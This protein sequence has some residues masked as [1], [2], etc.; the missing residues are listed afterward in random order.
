MR[1]AICAGAL[2]SGAFAAHVTADAA[3]PSAP[4]V[5][6][7]APPALDLELEPGPAAAVDTEPLPI[8][9][10]TP[11]PAAPDAE[12][13]P[14]LGGGL[15]V[16]GRTPHRLVLFTF[17]DGPDNRYT[18]RLL[19]ALDR[20]EIRATFFLTA[21]RIAGSTPW[22]R[23]NAEIAR[24]IA[25]RG[26]V[27]GSHGR[28]H[29]AL[30]RVS[31]EALDTQVDG[32]DDAIFE[33]LGIRPRLFR[34]PGGARS[35]RTDGYLAA[36]GYTTML[37][38]LGTGDP[39]VETPEA[40]LE[41]F[42]RVLAWR[43]RED[44]SRGGVVLM[45]DIHRWSLEAFPRIVALLDARNCE[46]YERGEE[47]YDFVED[48]SLFVVARPEGASPSDEAPPLILPDDVLAERQARARARAEA[49][50]ATTVASR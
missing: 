30:T 39:Q 46:L 10:S 35:P 26:H 38:N 4:M 22:A 9:T 5:E 11:A 2:G 13:S 3:V 40:V 43:E 17:D 49:R 12:A 41:T 28:D 18:R 47:L 48:P 23:D 24:E 34:P 21:G 36:R 42:R 15:V 45:H 19:D 37:W 29:V 50:C 27:I 33:V 25:R 44:G 32:A 6:A 7:G 16:T 20:A 14:D 1:A 31:G 8:A